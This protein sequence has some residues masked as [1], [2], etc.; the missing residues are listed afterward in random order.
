MQRL[1]GRIVDA[2]CR[3]LW[4]GSNIRRRNHTHTHA[5][6]HTHT[7]THTHARP[8]THTHVHAHARPHTQTHTHTHI[9]VCVHTHAHTH[10]CTHTHT[11]IHK[12]TQVVKWP[13][14]CNPYI[15]FLMGTL[16]MYIV[17]IT[18]VVLR[19]YWLDRANH[20]PWRIYRWGITG[21]FVVFM[22]IF[23]VVFPMFVRGEPC[24][25][26]ECLEDAR[27]WAYAVRWEPPT[28]CALEG[29]VSY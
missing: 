29:R 5:R 20:K 4:S 26:P 6:P 3:L 16:A 22:V 1:K 8:H 25:L 19:D 11:Y 14:L 10:A 17:I 13:V 18:T 23:L 12:R 28:C 7:H 27:V 2:G 15:I 24:S 9:R 21:L